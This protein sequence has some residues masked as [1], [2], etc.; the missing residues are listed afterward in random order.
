MGWGYSVG[1]GLGG[2]GEWMGWGC[3]GLMGM[4]WEGMDGD[5]EGWRWGWG[6]DGDVM[7]RGW[8]W[9]GRGWGVERERGLGW[10]RRL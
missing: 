10:G 6:C 8:E 5:G 3:E 1:R 7:G 4:V 9:T 2:D